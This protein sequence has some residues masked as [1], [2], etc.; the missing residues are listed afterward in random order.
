MLK[1]SQMLTRFIY[2]KRFCQ[3]RERMRLSLET[4]VGMIIHLRNLESRKRRAEYA[5]WKRA[6]WIDS[7]IDSPISD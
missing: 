7:A 1:F 2:T 3:S 6:F 5:Q 4:T